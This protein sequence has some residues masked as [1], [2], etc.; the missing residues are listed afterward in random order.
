M[1]AVFPVAAGLASASGT[2]TPEVWSGKTLVKFYDT[3]VFGDIANTDYEGEIKNFGDTV[4]IRTIPD[5]QISSYYIGM[6][7]SYERPTPA[8]VS[9]TIDKGQHWGM[10]INNLE[11]LQSD[12][13][14]VER[15]SDDASEGMAAAIDEDVIQNTYADASA[16]N[17]GATA[18]YR[19]SSY[20]LGI[21]GTP[22]LVD[23][24]DIIDWFVDLRSC[25][26]EQKGIPKSNRWLLLPPVFAGISMKSDIKD[27]SMMGD[28]TSAFRNGR[29]GMLAGWTIYDTNHLHSSGSE[30]DIMAGHQSAITF[31]S[32]LTENE[33]IPNPRDFG[34][35][36]RGL[37]A[38]GYKVLKEVSLIHSVLQ[39]G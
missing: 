12:I 3:T 36:M 32:Q 14:Y 2:Y 9:L 25:I 22:R 29:L 5:I 20:N 13:A 4:Q 34:K 11:Q 28:G 21:A 1:A 23:K 17:K 31:A 38:Y 6:N 27:A 39:K 8:K 35:L 18:G 33:V 37:Q 19:S 24:T 10:A 16:Y 7:I 15:W 26:D 30:W